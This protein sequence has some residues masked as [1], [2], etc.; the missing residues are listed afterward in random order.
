MSAAQKRAWLLAGALCGAVAS[1]GGSTEAGLE[2]LDA[3]GGREAFE[4][5]VRASLERMRGS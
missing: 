4:A 1:P 2:A 3:E 5:A